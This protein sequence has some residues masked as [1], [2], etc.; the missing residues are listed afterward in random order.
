MSARQRALEAWIGF[1][2]RREYAHGLA[3]VRIGVGAVLLADLLTIAWLGLVPRLW[4]PS[5]ELGFGP[6]SYHEPIC[7]FYR[8]FGASTSNAWVLFG[9]ACVSAACLCLG[10]FTRCS[11][12]LFV[13]SNAQLSQLSP[14]ADRGIDILL[15][16]VCLLL[17]CSSAGAT[18]SLDAR[19]RHGRFDRDV[20]VPAWPRY[21]LVLQLAV[22]Y[23]QSGMLKQSAQWTSVDGYS[24][25][26]V[27]L[28]RP[29][30]AR[31]ALPEWLLA[32]AYPM[33]QLSAVVTLIFE[34]GALLMPLLLW[35]HATRQRGGRWRAF[36][37]RSR[38]LQIWVCVGVGFHLMLAVLLVLGIFP[39]GC[40]ALYPALAQPGTWRSLG[41]RWLTPH[42][43]VMAA[44]KSHSG[45]ATAAK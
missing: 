13:L 33:L 17:A 6:A 43:G 29:H 4:G 19:L 39:W 12:L 1:W 34:R 30:F 36:V 38:I 26:Y 37:Q 15:R 16:N 24:A 10:L 18:W 8:W 42:T 45:L 9:L 5:N 7:W 14:A 2:D 35:L 41:R 27:V 23:F 31:I 3:L 20:Q 32:A 22:L 21:L 44:A 11:A 25:L 28:H 40:L